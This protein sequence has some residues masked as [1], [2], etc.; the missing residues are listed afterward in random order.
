MRWSQETKILV[1]EDSAQDALLIRTA[2]QRSGIR[3]SMDVVEDG[4]EA[5]QYLRGEGN[6]SNRRTSPL[7]TFILCDIKMPQMDGLQFLRWVRSYPECCRVPILL[8]SV[9][10]TNL[11]V[12]EAYDL[13]ANAYLLKPPTLE[14]LTELLRVTCDFWSRCA[15][16]EVNVTSA[17]PLLLESSAAR[18][19]RGPRVR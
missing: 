2:V 10:G 7:P 19:S 3:A 17:A 15:S 16:P 11:D 18:F 14:E 9:T 5:V 1:V 13:G 12:Q 6:Y 8:F 4:V